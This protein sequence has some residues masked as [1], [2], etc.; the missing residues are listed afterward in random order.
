MEK[1]ERKDIGYLTLLIAFPPPHHLPPSTFTSPIHMKKST[2]NH[3]NLNTPALRDP[4]LKPYPRNS[5]RL[6]P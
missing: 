4:C 2:S 6:K 5:P 1:R 3:P